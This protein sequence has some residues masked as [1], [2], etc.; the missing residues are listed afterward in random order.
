MKIVFVVHMYSL[1]TFLCK[2]FAKIS[3]NDDS[4]G[5]LRRLCRAEVLIPLKASDRLGGGSEDGADIKVF[6]TIKDCGWAGRNLNTK[7]MPMCADLGIFI[8][9]R[10]RRAAALVPLVLVA[11]RSIGFSDGSRQRLLRL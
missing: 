6:S 1:P 4:E 7:K 8:A 2:D 9:G 11:P 3:T 10:H 5:W